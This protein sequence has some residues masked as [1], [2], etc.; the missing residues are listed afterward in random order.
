MLEFH[1]IWKKSNAQSCDS[2]VRDLIF[3]YSAFLQRFARTLPMSLQFAAKF[4]DSDRQR[5]GICEVEHLGQER[6]DIARWIQCTSTLDRGSWWRAWKSSHVCCCSIPPGTHPETLST[7]PS[8]FSICSLSIVFFCFLFLSLSLSI[9]SLCALCALCALCVLSLSLYLY[10][11]S[12]WSRL[13]LS[14]FSVFFLLSLSLSLSLY[15]LSL[16]LSVSLSLSIPLSLHLSLS[17]SL[18]LSLSLSLS[19]SL[20]LYLPRRAP[21]AAPVWEW[22]HGI[23][24][25]RA[26]QKWCD[27]CATTW[28]QISVP[29]WEGFNALALKSAPTSVCK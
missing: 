8:N 12:L 17:L 22:V 23:C 10:L 6:V 14:V 21:I 7:P 20:F 24:R 25:P 26:M 28:V 15:L 27:T 13:S 16:S 4:E 9:C 29:N 2:E 5:F 19:L 3:F 18:Y 11:F 1:S